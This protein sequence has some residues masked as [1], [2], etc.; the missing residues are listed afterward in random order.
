MKSVQQMAKQCE[1]LLDTKDV[2][3]WEN[4]FLHGF[5]SRVS[6]PGF[7]P[8]E[9]QVEVLERIYKKHFA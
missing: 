5:T 3:E 9:K 6:F 7:T 2:S 1:G 8:T 4:D